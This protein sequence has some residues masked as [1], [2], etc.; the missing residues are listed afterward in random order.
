MEIYQH[1]HRSTS[2]EEGHPVKVLHKDKV[3][4]APNKEDRRSRVRALLDRGQSQGRGPLGRDQGKVN[5]H[6]ARVPNQHRDHLGMGR[7]KVRDSQAMGPDQVRV[8]L[9]KDHLGRDPGKV[10]VRRDKRMDPLNK[11]PGSL[12]QNREHQALGS[13]RRVEVLGSRE[14]WSLEEESVRCARPPS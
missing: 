12:H 5:D 4:G 11:D 6:Q 2:K 7:S 9:V 13:N 10:R 14:Q 8:P 1:Q 3:Q